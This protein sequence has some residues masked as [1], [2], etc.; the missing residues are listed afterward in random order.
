MTAWGL[1]R[2][3]DQFIS[4]DSMSP[5][6]KNPSPSMK[7]MMMRKEKKPNSM[8]MRKNNLRKLPLPK[9]PQLQPP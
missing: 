9:R 4:L 2:E 7:K 5:I 1:P 6:R 8:M 3:M